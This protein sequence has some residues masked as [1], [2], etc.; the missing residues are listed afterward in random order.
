MKKNALFG[1]IVMLVCTFILSGGLGA[2]MAAQTKS[3]ADTSEK[4]WGGYTAEKPLKL[5]LAY[6]TVQKMPP[7]LNYDPFSLMFEK[8]ADA[9]E[10]DTGGR[11][12]FVRYPSESLVKMGD[13][14]DAL[15][16]GMC[17]VG[18][19]FPPA[20]P[21]EFPSST[22]LALPGL[23]PNSTISGM[24]TQKLHEEGYTAED[25]KDVHV[26][27]HASNNSQDVSV[28]TR[29]IKSLDDWKGLKIAAQ[30]EPEVST[31]RALG[32]VPVGIPIFE[33]YIALERGTVDGAWIE[34]NGQVA[35]KFY[36][37]SKYFTAGHGGART[38]DYC[39]SKKTYESLPPAIK[40]V[41]DKNSGMLWSVM[42]GKHFDSNVVRAIGFLED[43]CK[44]KG[45][46]PINYPSK[47]DVAKL[48]EAW[49]PVHAK[50]IA[51][52]EAKGYPAQK[53]YQRIKELVEIYQSY[54]MGGLE[55]YSVNTLTTAK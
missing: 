6:W 41:V 21:G 16:F 52:L 49:E 4:D 19:V 24:V 45:Y 18:L 10:D 12:K 44:E 46:P 40:A 35:F 23:F 1:L 14:M 8:W 43:Y 48:R 20:V 34:F 9:I 29:Q 51:D 53:I 36:E 13:Y 27:W 26:L 2:S 17:D 37:V 28:R 25:W 39:M 7:P 11:V 42:T 50:V 47:D 38:L 32:A 33:Q 55:N 30:G 31:I 15:R 5:K 22:I 3:V 54:E